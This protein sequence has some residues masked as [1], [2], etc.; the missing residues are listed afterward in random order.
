MTDINDL[1]KK[2][3]LYKGLLDN[4]KDM[5][6]RMSL[7]DGRYEYVSSGA[8]EV[9][10][11][12]P[13]ELY[14]APLKLR[15]IIHPDW[16]DYFEEQR[17]HLLKGEGSPEYAFKVVH[18][19]GV[20][21]WV[22]QRNTLITDDDGNPIAIEGTVRDITESRKNVDEL[23]SAK[24]FAENLLETANTM[25]L[26]LDSEARI[27][28]FNRFAEKLTGYS[29]IEVIGRNWFDLFVPVRVK[30]IIPD[31]FEKALKNM[32]SAS[33]Y[34][35]PITIKNGEERLLP[36]SYTHLTLPTN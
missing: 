31:V 9:I 33:Q 15:E 30:E 13:D 2:T 17:S 36:V 23:K 18:R 14:E 34:E 8:V 3:R 16:L 29:K 4:S 11:Y 35:N 5:L 22:K 21:K 12:T 20:I 32:P 6:Y 10:G 19:S 26:T 28:T 1:K 24:D 7:P 25:V 27:T